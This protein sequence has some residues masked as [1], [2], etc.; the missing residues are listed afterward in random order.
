M[1]NYWLLTFGMKKRVD[2]FLQVRTKNLY[3]KKKGR[4]P[5]RKGNYKSQTKTFES[6]GTA[7]NLALRTGTFK[8][9][10]VTLSE[11]SVNDKLLRVPLSRYNFNGKLKQFLLNVYIN[12]MLAA[13]KQTTLKEATSSYGRSLKRKR[14]SPLTSNHVVRPPKKLKVNG[15]TVTENIRHLTNATNNKSLN[16]SKTPQKNIDKSIV[17]SKTVQKQKELKENQVFKSPS[18]E[19]SKFKIRLNAK[20]K[21]ESSKDA[22]TTTKQISKRLHDILSKNVNQGEIRNGIDDICDVR[23]YLKFKEEKNP[24][25]GSFNYKFQKLVTDVKNMNLPTVTWKIKVIIRQNKIS[26]I[27]FTNKQTLERSVTFASETE[28]YRIVIDNKSALLLGSPKTIDS[29]EDIEILLDILENID[30]NS[31]VILFR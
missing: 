13:L 15:S 16:T 6:N 26:A 31:P 8:S 27:S 21:K 14:S 5:S 10:E 3:F 4:P 22:K 7:I 11:T 29:P 12:S 17:S 1:V 20:S 9:C 19:K 28:R 2:Y 25:G 18:I 30:A 24:S 23:F